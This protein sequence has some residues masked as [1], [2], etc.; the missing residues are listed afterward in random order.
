MLALSRPGWSDLTTDV[1]FTELAAV[2]ESHGLRT[3][4]FGP[5]TAL[6]RCH[7]DPDDDK[8]PSPPLV[9]NAV[10][11]QR[12]GVLDAFYSLGSFVML[13]Q[14]T[15][16][17]ASAWS[18]HQ[19]SQPLYGAG[20][21][22]LGAMAVMHMLRTLGRLVLGHAL[23]LPGELPTERDLVAKLADALLPAVPCF[24]PHWRAMASAVLRLLAVRVRG[25]GTADD[26]LA[27]SSALYRPALALV[28]ADLECVSAVH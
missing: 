28:T 24:K 14:A 23:T 19:A 13:V 21:P 11:A 26:V 22:S 7:Q 4:L 12:R 16:A 5:Q 3:V 2:G 10:P 25:E 20:H 8:D 1:N 17:I 18:W 9:T 15:P 27:S 6:Q